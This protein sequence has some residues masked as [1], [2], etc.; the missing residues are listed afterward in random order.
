MRRRS[1]SALLPAAASLVDAARRV[2]SPENSIGRTPRKLKQRR[3][4]PVS[5][6]FLSVYREL[7]VEKS[8]LGRSVSESHRATT[9]QKRGKRWKRPGGAA[10]VPAAAGRGGAQRVDDSTWA[11]G[12]VSAT[13][14]PPDREA[15]SG[16]PLD[17]ARKW[18]CV[19][20]G[21]R[22][23]EAWDADAV[24]NQPVPSALGLP[25]LFGTRSA[26]GKARAGCEVCGIPGI[27]APPRA[28]RSSVLLA[29]AVLG[30]LRRQL[31]AIRAAALPIGLVPSSATADG[32]ARSPMRAFPIAQP[33]AAGVGAI[34]AAGPLESSCHR[35]FHPSHD[36]KFARLDM[37]GTGSPGLE[38][39]LRGF[40]GFR[41]PLFSVGMPVTRR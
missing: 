16:V 22:D 1:I 2:P 10:R 14:L 20:L 38:A 17:G 40:R 7:D 24:D 35:S 15:S 41:H 37:C 29:G 25:G 19:I 27:S 33:F 13:P 36:L 26:F 34:H 39:G 11:V 8:V 5:S 21:L 30:C 23:S 28:V 12:A 31:A 6:P 32:F 9:V 18:V 4:E 3:F